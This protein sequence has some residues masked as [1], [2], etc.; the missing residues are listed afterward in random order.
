MKVL[1]FNHAKSIALSFTEV[2]IW[3]TTQRRTLR[4]R[5]AFKIT[6]TE[7]NVIAMLASIGLSKI[8]KKG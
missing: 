6:E 4:S 5:S 3:L 7:L 8:P 1:N 2:P